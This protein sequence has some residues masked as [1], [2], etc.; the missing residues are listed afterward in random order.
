[1][2]TKTYDFLLKQK[3]RFVFYINM[4]GSVL[5]PKLLQELTHH[6]TP[7]WI[8][9]IIPSF[10]RSRQASYRVSQY[11]AH[12]IPIY[13]GGPQGA[14]LSPTLFKIYIANIITTATDPQVS[15]AAYADDIAL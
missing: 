5:Y 14:V 10:L 2:I 15:I 4:F 13:Q 3:S 1:M 8:V 9:N 12:P 7:T 6:L 11:T